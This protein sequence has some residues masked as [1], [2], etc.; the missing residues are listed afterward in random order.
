MY[1]IEKIQRNGKP[2]YVVK[3]E[4]FYGCWFDWEWIHVYKTKDEAQNAINRLSAR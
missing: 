2:Y 4:T 3:K 1:K